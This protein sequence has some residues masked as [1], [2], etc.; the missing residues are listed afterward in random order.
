MDEK[1]IKSNLNLAQKTNFKKYWIIVLVG[2]IIVVFIGYFILKP[3][4][5]QKYKNLCSNITEEEKFACFSGLSISENNYQICYG[6][7]NRNDKDLC[8]LNYMIITGQQLCSLLNN[9][10][11][12]ADCIKQIN[13]KEKVED[14]YAIPGIF[15]EIETIYFNCTYCSCSKE[16]LKRCNEKGY[17]HIFLTEITY[18][19]DPGDL[20]ECAGQCW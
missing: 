1:E 17:D 3:D 13:R 14:P 9:K 20:I 12:K 18:E 6:L 19:V 2:I 10:E 7:S 11:L 16:G 8:F 5:Y 4:N 15:D